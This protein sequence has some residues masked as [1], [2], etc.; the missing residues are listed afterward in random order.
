MRASKEGEDRKGE[1]GACRVVASVICSCFG[2]ENV[3][4]VD[5]WCGVVVRDAGGV[6]V[7]GGGKMVS[8]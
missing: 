1:C 4:C 3:W 6:A 8:K 2:A 5:V 7:C